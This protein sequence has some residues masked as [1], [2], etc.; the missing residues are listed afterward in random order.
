MLKQ[1][2][3]L[4]KIASLSILMLGLETQTV[5][6]F[7]VISFDGKPARWEK[8]KT[9]QVQL[10]SDFGKDFDR[11]GCDDF[12]AC[13]TPATAVQSAMNEWK[14][15]D[16]I[17]LK[18]AP[19]QVKKISSVPSYDG[20]NQIKLYSSQWET[21]PGAFPSSALAV[22]I[23]T[24]GGDGEIKDSDIFIN[25]KNF[26][27]AVVNAGEENAFHDVE[28][29]I[30]HE[31]GHFLGL[32]H[33]STNSNE[34]DS[35]RYNAT[36]FYASLP[37][38]TFR[39]SLD[40][41]DVS[42]IQH[43]YS[44]QNVVEPVVDDVTPNDVQVSFKG[45]TIVEIY[46]DN[47]LPTTSV[48]LARTTNDGDIVGRVMSVQSNKIKVA[49]D[50]SEMQTGEYDLV[51]ANTYNS[52]TRVNNAITVDN[53]YVMGT[54]NNDSSS[55]ESG[56]GGCQSNGSSSLLFFLIPALLILPRRLKNQQI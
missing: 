46:G 27:W 22:T 50:F 17:D 11:F 20:I 33:T 1:N 28:N 8:N 26:D 45:N 4:A 43:L 7:T 6:A 44:D 15:V 49:I 37:G 10:D 35:A 56:G 18:F 32:D 39:R 31:M 34:L 12:G 55:A 24:Y 25:A 29:V 48:V 54:Y 14:N 19:L 23:S 21:L 2:C 52:F 3:T 5:E 13:V 51:V 41:L 38:E 53:A 16:D 9:I 30:T 47:F 42:G 40:T 36:M